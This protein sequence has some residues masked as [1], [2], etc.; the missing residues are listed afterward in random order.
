MTSPNDVYALISGTCE[1]VLLDDKRDFADIM[2]M[3]DFEMGRF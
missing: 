1:Y 3:T 2:K